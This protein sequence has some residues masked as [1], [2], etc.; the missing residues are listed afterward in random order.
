MDPRIFF[1]LKSSYVT[2]EVG[3]ELILVPLTENI[4]QMN[5]LFTMNATGRI[6][7][8][9]ISEDCTMQTLINKITENFDITE[10]KAEEDIKEFL[11]KM[12]ALMA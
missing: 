9:N 2:R 12:Q 3:N 11:S 4:S 8:E 10:K 1:P 7:W 6:I 5:D